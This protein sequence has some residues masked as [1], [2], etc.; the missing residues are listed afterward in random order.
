LSLGAPDI[1]ETPN[2]SQCE[3]VKV[4]RTNIDDYHVTEL[5]EDDEN[6]AVTRRMT[7]V[8]F[9]QPR[10]TRAFE[11]SRAAAMKKLLTEENKGASVAVGSRRKTGNSDKQA[12]ERGSGAS[13]S[14]RV[15]SRKGDSLEYIADRQTGR[16]QPTTNGGSASVSGGGGKA[17]DRSALTS[18]A[19]GGLK[20]PIVIKK[21]STSPSKKT[22][23]L[24]RQPPKVAV[25]ARIPRPKIV[26]YAPPKPAI[27][28]PEEE[29]ESNDR[30]AP[31]RSEM[32]ASGK[33]AQWTR[34]QKV[35]M[36]IVCFHVHFSGCA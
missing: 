28:T 1:G 23:P 5:L 18:K 15:T 12:F 31:L 16:Q 20:R 35:S 9:K 30:V 19:G 33:T 6:S 3:N 36:I 11:L 17:S 8:D 21:E 32:R 26:K 27:E 4:E 13:Q 7:A 29:E 2:T 24:T 22:E 25:P 14:L 34:K 10:A